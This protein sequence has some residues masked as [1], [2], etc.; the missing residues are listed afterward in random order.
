MLLNR[1]AE[2][3]QRVAGGAL[4][5]DTVILTGGGSAMLHDRLLPLL[6]HEHV[7]LADEPGSIHLA[8]VRGGLEAVAAVRA[9]GA[10]M[11][12]VIGFRLD[13][14]NPREARALDVLEAWQEQGF[15][16][17]YVLTE[18]LLRLDEDDAS[19]TESELQEA[20]A[21]LSRLLEVLRDR[22]YTVPAAPVDNPSQPALTDAFIGSVRQAARS[23][24]TLG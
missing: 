2:T 6:G 11:S 16:L 22:S 7:V 21:Q 12:R 13:P 5:W 1:I 8:N 15:S 19:N 17:R 20:L 14:D 24:L 4:P 3:Y 18:A 23:G 10:A 9:A